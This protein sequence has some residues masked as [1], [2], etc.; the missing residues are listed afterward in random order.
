MKIIIVGAGEVGTHLALQIAKE[1]I[2]ITLMDEN[3]DRLEDL[4]ANYDMLTVGLPTSIQ[5]L[6]M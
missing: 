1:H 2:D 6:K 5:D 3:P 4:E